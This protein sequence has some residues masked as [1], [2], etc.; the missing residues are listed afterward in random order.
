MNLSVLIPTINRVNF[1]LDKI[2]FYD[3]LKFNGQIIIIDSSDDKSF[4]LIKKIISSFKNLNI[5]HIRYFGNIFQAIQE[6]STYIKKDFAVISGDDDYLIPKNMQKCIDKINDKGNDIIGCHGQ[7]L[8]CPINQSHEKNFKVDYY[9][10]PVI[11]K[12]NSFDRLKQLLTQYGVLNFSVF[13]KKEFVNSFKNYQK[14]DKKVI[15]YHEILNQSLLAIF[16]KISKINEITCIRGSHNQRIKVE[17]N[18]LAKFKAENYLR[19]YDILENEIIKNINIIDNLPRAKTQEKVKKILKL[20]F[21]KRFGLIK[22]NTFFIISYLKKI[23]LSIKHIL[24]RRFKKIEE[25]K[26]FLLVYNFLRK[27]EKI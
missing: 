7:A 23:N 19:L 24:L 27:N 26:D 21:K 2:K 6:G 4:Q 11:N 9:F 22:F 14:L 12:N 3:E 17:V 10:D 15:E 13:K 1:I 5:S 16:G 18:N 8:V 20:F 25:N